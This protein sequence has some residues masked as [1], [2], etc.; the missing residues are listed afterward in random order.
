[1]KRRIFRFS[2]KDIENLTWFI[3][4][5]SRG[6]VASAFFQLPLPLKR[7]CVQ[8]GT[9][10]G[11]MALHAPNSEIPVDMSR[12]DYANAVRYGSLYHDIG[13]YLV[14]N[15]SGMYP[16]A[17]VR[18]LRE[19]LDEVKI[20]PVPRQIIL[21]TVQSCGERYDGQGYPDKL[22][23]DNIPFH[24]GIC[25]IANDIDGMIV[26]RHGFLINAV[27]DAKKYVIENKGTAFFPAAVGCFMEAYA[28][29]AQVYSQW[30]KNP[31]FWKNN[32]IKPLEKHINRSIG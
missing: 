24:A 9:I 4:D 29:I 25:A 10:A 6:L 17:G 20:D 19:Q 26:G 13:A 27:A 5:E 3:Y 12:E 15:Q 14:Y 32:D 18:F 1:M 23:G 11:L 28:E 31:P 30:R 21:E 22:A 8:V 16:D 7:H 2:K